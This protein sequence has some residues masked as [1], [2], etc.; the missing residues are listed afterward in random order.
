M[1]TYELSQLVLQSDDELSGLRGVGWGAK[2]GAT[3]W[4]VSCIKSIKMD[5]FIFIL[6]ICKCKN[7]CILMFVCMYMYRNVRHNCCYCQLLLSHCWHRCE[8]KLGHALALLSKQPLLDFN[9]R[10]SLQTLRPL[11]R[12]QLC[13]VHVNALMLNTH[14]HSH[15]CVLFISV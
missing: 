15:V 10:C 3:A 14:T 11:L 2:C 13:R 6:Y 7:V 4:C 12:I 1:F 9:R 5:T 8:L